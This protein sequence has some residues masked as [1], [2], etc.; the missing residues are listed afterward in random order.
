[1][2]ELVESIARAL[3]DH[4]EDVQVTLVEGSQAAES[5]AGE[6][7]NEKPA[8]S[9]PAATQPPPES[10]APVFS[11]HPPKENKSRGLLV[12]LLAFVIAGG[13]LYGAWTYEPGFRATAQPQVDRILQLAGIA[14]PSA[15]APGPR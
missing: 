1:M 8:P 7:E 4:P 6:V 2:K 9:K 13:G 14:H 10:F 11:T 3:V 15:P 5:Q 12:A